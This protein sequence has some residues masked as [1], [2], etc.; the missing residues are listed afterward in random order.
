[1][2][3]EQLERHC[4]SIIAKIMDDNKADDTEPANEMRAL[5]KIK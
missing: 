1:M 5:P 2:T 4:E 3:K